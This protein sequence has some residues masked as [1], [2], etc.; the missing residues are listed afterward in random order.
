MLRRATILTSFVCLVLA[1]G[2]NQSPTVT[3]RTATPIQ[4]TGQPKLK[5]MKLWMG[6][7]EISAELALTAQQKADGMMHRTNMGTMDGMLFVFNRSTRQ[8][9]WMKNTIVPLDAAYI[10]PEGV[11]RE[12][13]PLEPLN[14]T[15]VDSKSSDIQ[16]VLEMNRDWFSNHN[17]RV[18]M[19]IRSEKGSLRDTFFGR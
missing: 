12:I 13:Y 15:P 8:G 4:K 10:D 18:G 3:S 6:T 19:K 5:T 1:V 14:E 2:C 17:V 7:H 16:Y 11:I 9:F